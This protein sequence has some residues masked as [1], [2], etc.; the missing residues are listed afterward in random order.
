MSLTTF[1][2]I[3]AKFL[4]PCFPIAQLLQIFHETLVDILKNCKFYVVC[5]DE[6]MNRVIQRG[7]MDLVIRYWSE[8]V[9]FVDMCCIYLFF[10]S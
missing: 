7:K 1:L 8:A 3:L 4:E 9:V 6:A 5:F 10:I 2:L